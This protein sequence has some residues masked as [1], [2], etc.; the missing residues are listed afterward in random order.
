M[1]TVERA[2][3]L[4]RYDPETGIIRWAVDVWAG[5]YRNVRVM[6]EGDVAGTKNGT[7]YY[8]I[9]AD[10]HRVR[11][12]RLAWLL[13]YGQSPKALIDHIDGD[14]TNNRIANLREATKSQNGF[15]RGPERGNK[16]GFKGVYWSSQKRKW[17][18]E[19][20]VRGKRKHI[21]FYD[22][23]QSAGNAYAAAALVEHGE[24]AWPGMV[25][26]GTE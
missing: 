18:A 1:I 5:R 8:Y 17:H 7:G 10:G 16:S 12:H 22:T 4:F 3:E 14:K 25:K 6:K 15:N 20:R 23:P 24:F 21:G 19:M 11:A 9:V 13:F 26:G 2:R